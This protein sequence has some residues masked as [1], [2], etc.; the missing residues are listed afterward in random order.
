MK[1][2][3]VVLALP[4]VVVFYVNSV[5]AASIRVIVDSQALEVPLY[6]SN[7][8]IT[9]NGYGVDISHSFNEQWSISLGAQ[10][11]DVNASQVSPL[12]SIEAEQK[13]YH[14]DIHYFYQHYTFSLAYQNINF[15]LASKEALDISQAQKLDKFTYFE[16][17]N[18]QSIAVNISRDFDFDDFWLTLD[19][20]AAHLSQQASYDGR[21]VVN[22]ANHQFF[23][24][25]LTDQSMSSWFA[26]SLL[27]CST[28]WSWSQIT[29][30]PSMQLGFTH[31]LAGDD[32]YL[33]NT[34]SGS[35]RVSRRTRS[36]DQVREPL[37]GN[38]ATTLAA[39]LTVFITDNF[40]MD[41]NVN[42]LYAGSNSANYVSIGFGWEF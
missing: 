1:H 10:Y 32:V 4:L 36:Q 14:S 35:T 16:E 17:I 19:M 11:S 20:G 9:A 21:I 7:R 30:V 2:S 6:N 23:S 31:V 34:V 25:E 33:L 15:E 3:A 28:F 29:F 8:S 22:G 26:S 18:S 40:S 13:D 39:A 5:V 37:T 24:R 12:I 27:S 41:V 42:R 38:S